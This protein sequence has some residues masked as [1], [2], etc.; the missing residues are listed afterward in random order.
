[1]RF[2]E[3]PSYLRL[4][5]EAPP[6]PV[7][8]WLESPHNLAETVLVSKEIS[9]Q[10]TYLAEQPEL[11]PNL[12]LALTQLAEALGG[13]VI[14]WQIAEHTVTE[15]FQGINTIFDQLSAAS[16]QI[17]SAKFPELAQT[18]VFALEKA[19]GKI[20]ALAERSSSSEY[21]QINPAFQ[22]ILQ[23]Y[24]TFPNLRPQITEQLP[25]PEMNNPGN[26]DVRAQDQAR[27]DA[28][29]ETLKKCTNVL[30]IISRLY[31]T[32]G[33]EPVYFNYTLHSRRL[34]LPIGII[35][36]IINY[37]KSVAVPPD[38]KTSALQKVG[39]NLLNTTNTPLPN[40]GDFKTADIIVPEVNQE[41]ANF[42]KNMKQKGTVTP[43]DCDSW[44]ALV[45]FVNEEIHPER[46][47]NFTKRDISGKV[48]TIHTLKG[49]DVITDVE[50][51]S[52]DKATVYE[53]PEALTTGHI[54]P[55]DKFLIELRTRLQEILDT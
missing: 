44:P 5:T 36:G 22:K 46:V 25:Q 12:Q 27:L 1:M 53:L 54:K 33:S 16:Q 38:A 2:G 49:K 48:D 29:G 7:F 55:E 47:F 17:D 40:F 43:A 52:F 9:T 4:V 19:L 20:V 6:E 14:G 50:N 31:V 26:W 24:Q 21:A 51:A 10:S 3:R 39:G 11:A 41:F 13:E 42:I 23:I 8:D 37:V 35:R 32:L 18:V 30:E 15:S 28:I 34:Q 45:W